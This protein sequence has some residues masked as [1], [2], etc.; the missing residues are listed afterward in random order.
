MINIALV[1]D[2]K[3]FVSALKSLIEKHLSNYHILFDAGNG[4]EM[5]HKLTPKCKPEIILLDLN[6]P[7]KNGF[8]TSEWLALNYPEI[9][10]IILSTREDRE[11]VLKLIKSGIRG[12]LLKDAEFEEFKFA[13]E[14]VH[15]GGL[16]YP[17]FVTQ[18]LLHNLKNPPEE[19]KHQPRLNDRELA[20]LKLTATE[21]TY[22]EIASQLCVSVRTIDGYRDH[23][24]Y[25]LNIKS[26]TG[27]AVYAI[28]N[29]I[30]FL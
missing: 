29:K 18:H 26:R 11:S 30:C 15:F 7:V 24:F 17:K 28:K 25:K 20:F 14:E 10:V 1:D 12:Y 8:E 5:I 22:K 13:L 6:M 16:Y 21:L 19:E 23:L 4:Q 27:L 9:R 2:H 3:L